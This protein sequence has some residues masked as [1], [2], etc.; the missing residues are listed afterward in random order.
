MQI[1]ATGFE[2]QISAVKGK[3]EVLTATLWKHTWEWDL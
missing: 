1:P 3:Y 2:S